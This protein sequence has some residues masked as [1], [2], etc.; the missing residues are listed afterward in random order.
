[1]AIALS[2]A[3]PS[4]GRA[5]AGSGTQELDALFQELLRNPADRALNLRFIEAAFEIKDYEAA[6]GALDR[7]LFF[8]PDNPVYLLR[9]GEAYLAL[10]SYAAARGF[11]E[12]VMQLPTASAEQ[13]EL[14]TAKIA[15]IERRTRPSPWTL[16]AQ[17][18]LRYQSNASAGPDGLDGVDPSAE[19]EADWNA[20]GLA[21]VTFN[22]PVGNGAIEASLTTY[23]ADQFEIDRLDLGVAELVAGPRFGIVSGENSSLSLKPFGLASGVLLGDDPYLGVYGGGA[24]A[25]A[26][27]GDPLTLEPYF[28]YRNR[29]YFN[30]DD[31]PDAEDETGDLFTYAVGGSG[32]LGETVTWFGRGGFKDNDARAGHESYDEYFLDLS[33]RIAFGG[34]SAAAPWLLTPSFSAEWT[35]YDAPNLAVDPQTR[36]DFEWRAGARLDVPLWEALGLG[37]QVQYIRNDSNIS[38]YDYDNLQIT[39]GPTVRF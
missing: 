23:Y 30:S 16:Y 19:A 39:S 8:E 32:A 22:Q 18:G 35:D 37:I 2:L 10:E 5:Q 9:I 11:Y 28:E 12:T 24:S 27:L 6:I 29:T 14:A 7:L 36:E 1:M 4:A 25:R 13:K 17:A 34:G 15:E 26:R 31:Y 21:V 33:V 20:F 3:V 38:R